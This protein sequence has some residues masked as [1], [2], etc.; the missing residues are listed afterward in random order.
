MK[1]IHVKA[2]GGSRRDSLI[3]TVHIGTASGSYDVHIGADFKNAGRYAKG[4]HFEGKAFIVTDSN[5]FPL[6]GEALADG[7]RADGF[8][9]GM[10]ILPAGEEHKR[11]GTIEKLYNAFHEHG[12]TRSDLIIALGGGVVGDMTGF[13]AGTYLRGVPF[14]QIPTTLL[15][16]IDSSVGGKTGVDMDYGKNLVGMFNQPVSVLVDPVMLESLP[17]AIFADGMAEAIKYGLIRDEGLFKKFGESSA[18]DLYAHEIIGLIQ[19]CVSIKNK[20]VTADERDTGERMI[21][22][23]GHTIGHAIEKCGNYTKYSHG[24]AVAMGMV[25]AAEIGEKLGIT[26]KG[27]GTSIISVLEKYGLPTR[28][29]EKKEDIFQG[30]LSDKKKSGDRISLILLERIGSAVIHPV[31]TD[32]L[33]ELLAEDAD[34]C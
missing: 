8:D 9:T 21:L 31:G 6:Y 10:I 14:M 28:A 5:V 23:F 25:Y 16:Q 33:K 7:V 24:Q 18:E 15:A 26:P 32:E 2:C 13:A 27:T 29:D 4:L 1:T 30:I 3:E 17:P 12:I 19:T 11:L 22:N 20:V 34:L